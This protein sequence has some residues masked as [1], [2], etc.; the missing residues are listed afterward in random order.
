VS[1]KVKAVTMDLKGNIE[2]IEIDPKFAY[3]SVPVFNKG[4]KDV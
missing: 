4:G 2:E 3:A 1:K